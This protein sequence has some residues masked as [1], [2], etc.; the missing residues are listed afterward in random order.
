M[1]G[2]AS[3]VEY[4]YKPLHT[5]TSIRI[6][7][8][9]ADSH[10][11]PLHGRLEE[12]QLE[13]EPQ[14][15]ALSYV[16]GSS[17]P[18]HN[19]SIDG[20]LLKLRQNLFDAIRRL[21]MRGTTYIWI[22]AICINQEDPQERSSQVVLMRRIYESASEVL[23]YL[24]ESNIGCNP[25]RLFNSILHFD[26]LLTAKGED[27]K[28]LRQSIEWRNLTQYGLPDVF[29]AQWQYLISLLE[30]P[31]FSRVWVFQESLVARE[32]KFI[33]GDFSFEQQPFFFALRVMQKF[34]FA[35]YVDRKVR[36][37]LSPLR[38]AIARCQSILLRQV[39]FPALCGNQTWIRSPLIQLLR[40]DLASLSEASD[41]R[42]YVFAF[43]GVSNEAEEPALRPDYFESVD[44]LYMRVA[45]YMVENGHGDL[46]L[47][48]ALG[49]YEAETPS[50]VPRWGKKN[51]WSLLHFRPRSMPISEVFKAAGRTATDFHIHKDQKTL[52]VRGIVLDTIKQ[53]G[54][55]QYIPVLGS[56]AVD[57][58][59]M[60]TACLVEILHMLPSGRSYPTGEAMLEV[61]C[62]LS[63]CDRTQEDR[64]APKEYQEGLGAFI[65]I[66]AARLLEGQ[67]QSEGQ[68]KLVLTLGAMVLATILLG[69]PKPSDN[70]ETR[71][72]AREFQVTA[73][74][75]FRRAIR[76]ITER[77]YI[78]QVPEFAEVGDKIIIIQGCDV[79]YLLRQSNNSQYSLICDCYI[80]GIMYGEAWDE[81]KT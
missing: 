38:T 35:S 32:C 24:G 81:I 15:S 20:S 54:T 29:D 65:S 79:P 68:G 69:E 10:D 76:C 50:W 59:E 47:N 5:R 18:K 8:I 21:R 80:H 58:N 42:D 2:T 70:V 45:K 72:W 74:L 28:I 49:T 48:S 7:Q 13:Q 3:E 22:D 77:G 14:Y 53:L 37:R 11:A 31:W 64:K 52:I 61:L 1:Q 73:W 57:E 44:Q 40:E 16:W 41:P 43:L 71:K 55:S 67:E 78:G 63:V 27:I 4:R 25:S 39:L 6:L 51:S 33:S 34:D 36:T 12:T 46:L 9:F 30:N 66:M 17:I 26:N 60:V 75:Q 56:D 19:L 23:V 62:R